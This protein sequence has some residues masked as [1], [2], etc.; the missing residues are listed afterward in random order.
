MGQQQVNEC[1]MCGE[2]ANITTIAMWDMWACSRPCLIAFI[3]ENIGTTYRQ[4]YYMV[5]QQKEILS[6]AKQFENT[7]G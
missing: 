6:L 4:F 1:V 2:A 3:H 7:S 5:D